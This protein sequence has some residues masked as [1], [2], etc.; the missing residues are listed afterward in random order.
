[1]SDD[2]DV[3]DNNNYLHYMNYKQTQRKK[4]NDNDE[5]LLD[6]NE[7]WKLQFQNCSLEFNRMSMIDLTTT[8]IKKT[9]L[10]V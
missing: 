9:G 1:M 6:L 7:L 4:N 3:D 10:D 5:S 2:D 8:M